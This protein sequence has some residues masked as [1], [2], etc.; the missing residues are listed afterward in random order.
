MGTHSK[1]QDSLVGATVSPGLEKVSGDEIIVNEISFLVS[2]EQGKGVNTAGGHFRI[3]SRKH[4]SLCFPK[5]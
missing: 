1:S 3:S 5:Y 2:A 4:G